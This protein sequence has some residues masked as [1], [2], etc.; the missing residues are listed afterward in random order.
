[1][2]VTYLYLPLGSGNALRA[3]RSVRGN[4][5]CQ[6]STYHVCAHTYH[7]HLV[8]AATW[9]WLDAVFDDGIIL[10]DPWTVTTLMPHDVPFGRCTIIQGALVGAQSSLEGLWGL[11]KTGEREG[12]GFDRSKV[13]AQQERKERSKR[14]HEHPGGHERLLGRSIVVRLIRRASARWSMQVFVGAHGAFTTCISRSN[15]LSASAN[16]MHA[17]T[18]LLLSSLR[19]SLKAT[20]EVPGH[21]WT[22]TRTDSVEEGLALRPRP[23]QESASARRRVPIGQSAHPVRPQLAASARQHV[24]FDFL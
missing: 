5:T 14:S 12:P 3:L 23:L 24:S 16:V 13:E 1:M 18:W 22:A 20:L 19:P 8:D 2:G 21:W 4:N 7:M 6:K 9:R 17:I 10:S 15:V 11:E